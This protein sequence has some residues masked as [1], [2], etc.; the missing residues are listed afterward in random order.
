L[1]TGIV[2][3]FLGGALGDLG[4]ELN[5]HQPVAQVHDQ[6]HDVFDHQDRDP[7]VADFE[8]QGDHV[9]ELAFAQSRCQFV[10]E[11]QFR[12]GSQGTGQVQPLELNGVELLADGVFGDGEVHEFEHFA[13]VGRRVHDR[14]RPVAE[15]GRG[16]HVFQHG[17]LGKGDGDLEGTRQPPPAHLLRGLAGSIFAKYEHLARRGRVQPGHGVDQGGLA[18]PVGADQPHDITFVDVHGHRVHRRQPAELFGQ[19][20]G[21]EYDHTRLFLSQGVGLAAEPGRLPDSARQAT[22]TGYLAIKGF[23]F[24]SS[25]KTMSP[26]P[27]VY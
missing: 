27:L 20:L 8:N 4:A 19:F 24:Q 2:G 13:A 14:S 11:K 18:R 21:L 3:H 17:H 15:N 5:A 1:V 6:L 10:Q 23:T 16:H 12:T 25:G 26:L 7:L 22:K 9:L